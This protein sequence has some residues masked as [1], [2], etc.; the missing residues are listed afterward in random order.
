MGFR[1]APKSATLNDLE[2][3]NGWPLFCL[4]SA[5]SGTF[6]R[7]A[8]KFTFAIS[9]PDEFLYLLSVRSV[10][11]LLIYLL[12]TRVIKYSVSTAIVWAFTRR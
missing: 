9:S 4:I 10:K 5:N 6:R 11:Y 8:V 7:T 1:M 12:S 3:R 2:R